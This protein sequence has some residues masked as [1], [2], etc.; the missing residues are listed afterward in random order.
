LDEKISK[1]LIDEFIDSH[2]PSQLVGY[3]KIFPDNLTHGHVSVPLSLLSTCKEGTRCYSGS[4]I[5]SSLVIDSGA[6]VC[7][8][9]HKEDFVAYGASNM[10][11][12]DLSSSNTVAGEGII[13]WRLRDVNG[14]T[15]VIEVKGYHIPHAD[16]RLLSPQVLL[17]AMGGSSIQTTGGVELKLD[18]GIALF[19]PHCPHS[20]LPLLPLADSS[21]PVRCFWSR[22]FSFTS[23]ESTV[24][25]EIKKSLLND[26]NTN[27]SLSQKEVLLWH[28]RLSHAS[29]SWVQS[30]MRHRTFLPCSTNYDDKHALHQGPFI[31]TNSRAP[32]CNV[33]GL[34]CAACLCAKASVQSP[35]KLPPR[36]S[37]KHKKLKINNLQ[38]GSC[39]SADHYF[40]PCLSSS[41]SKQ[42][43]YLRNSTLFL[44]TL[45]PL[46]TR[47]QA[48]NP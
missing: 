46:F 1:R 40:S 6:S 9:P 15:V 8:S 29:I 26:S 30:L 13:S 17:S 44:M 27:L 42:R 7:I 23:H 20:N 11:I 5:T 19:A 25:N 2:D 12:K 21:H 48:A 43:K 41:M 14:T 4:L 31:R 39:I 10:K 3:D 45:S 22:A 28:Q 34:K 36:Q 16:I 38:P 18:N 37:A 47:Y 33:A 24:I 35:S 32:T